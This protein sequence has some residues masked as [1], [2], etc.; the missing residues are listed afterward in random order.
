VEFSPINK[1]MKKITIIGR[2]TAGAL[3]AAYFA[4]QTNWIIDWIYDPNIKQQA[5]GEGTNLL[6]PTRLDADIDF[7]VVE[8]QSIYG[9]P[10][11]GIRKM[12]WGTKTKDFTHTFPGS[13]HGYHFNAVMLQD[14]II[15]KLSNNNRVRM[16]HDHVSHHNDLNTD[17]VLDCSGR[18]TDYSEFN[19]RTEIPV[20]AVSVKQC[21]WDGARFTQTLTIARPYGWVFGIPLLNRCA[22][23]YMYNKDINTLEEVQE[24]VKEVYKE[25]NL[26]PS[27]IGNQFHFTNYIRKENFVGESVYNGN[28]SFFLE[29]LEATSLGSMIRINEWALKYFNKKMTS[30]EANKSY[31]N[32]IDDISNMIMLHYFAGSTFKTPFWDMAVGRANSHLNKAKQNKPFVSMI[33][34]CNESETRRKFIFSNLPEIG[35]WPGRSYLQNLENLG[36]KE[37][38]SQFLKDS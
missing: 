21:F 23:G 1:N 3:A 10:K 35:T 9:T 33:H 22:I 19:M 38:L 27:D 37:K 34:A 14:W 32:D 8:L 15:E 36:I 17:F 12:N 20:N 31:H 29:P 13:L 4:K 28:A 30:D 24:D 26:E 18:P 25:F 5:V 6:V 2:G 7:N 16:L 11:L